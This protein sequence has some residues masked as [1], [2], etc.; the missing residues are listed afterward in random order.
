SPVG[1]SNL[2]L[3]S[4]KSGSSLEINLVGGIVLSFLYY[5]SLIFTPGDLRRGIARLTPDYK[6]RDPN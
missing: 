1:G 3:S 4:M 6:A 5:A 2:S